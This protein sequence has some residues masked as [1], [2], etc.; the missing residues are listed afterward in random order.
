MQQFNICV[1]RSLNSDTR[2]KNKCVCRPKR[3][4]ILP[5]ILFHRLL[6]GPL[7]LN[8]YQKFGFNQQCAYTMHV[9]EIGFEVVN[10]FPPSTL[11][12]CTPFSL[13]NDSDVD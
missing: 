7:L 8:E 4:E 11:Y 2:Q 12:S 5:T 9:L 10:S 6:V 3:I 13:I 1:M